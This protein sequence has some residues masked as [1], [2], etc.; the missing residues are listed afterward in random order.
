[1]YAS[2]GIGGRGVIPGRPHD[3]FGIGPYWLKES[4]DLDSQPGNVVGDE[5]GGEMFYNFAITPFAQLSL[6]TQW[7]SPGIVS[8]D[9]AVFLGTRLNI[10]F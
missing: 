2:G 4:S 9:T 8:S 3:R 1:M 10:R 7:I 5:V 6:D